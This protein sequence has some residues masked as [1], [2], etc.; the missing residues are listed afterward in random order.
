[1]RKHDLIS[2]A[3]W[4]FMGLSILF[5][6]PSFGLGTLSVPGP[7][8]MSFIAGAIICVFS[9]VTFLGAL[10]SKN[11]EA[12]VHLW[13]KL[14]YFKLVSVLVLLLAYI[15]LVDTLGFIISTFLL[16]FLLMRFQGSLGWFQSLLGALLTTIC[17]YF[18]F[19]FWLKTS[20]PKGVIISWVF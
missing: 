7:G 2:S 18:I 11:E 13:T 19:D 10:F 8:F 14:N 12:T 15:F 17:C 9:A 5:S 16:V 6:S 20:L 3:V 1:M 4:F